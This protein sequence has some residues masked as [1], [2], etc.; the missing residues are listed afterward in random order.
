[1]FSIMQRVLAVLAATRDDAPP[2]PPSTRQRTRTSTS[3]L[4]G[5]ATC[6]RHSLHV[7]ITSA[8]HVHDVLAA[9]T[10]V[11]VRTIEHDEPL[12]PKVTI[13]QDIP[14]S[15]TDARV[16]RVYESADEGSVLDASSREAVV[17]TKEPRRDSNHHDAN[18]QILQK[19]TVTPECAAII[20][21]LETMELLD[22]LCS[23][24]GAIIWDPDVPGAPY[25]ALTPAD[26]TWDEFTDRCSNQPIPQWV[27]PYLR[28]PLLA[29]AFSPYGPTE[30]PHDS[31]TEMLPLPIP[32]F[33][34]S[35]FARSV[36][37]TLK[38]A[39]YQALFTQRHAYKA[40]AYVT[41]LVGT[42]VRAFY[43]AP[44]VLA[45]LDALGAFAWSDPAAPLL[46]MYRNC[47]MVTIFESE[48]ACAG[49]PHIV[50]SGTLPNAPWDVEPA[51]LPVQDESMLYVPA[52]SYI[53]ELLEEQEQEAEA[54]AVAEEDGWWRDDE[55]EGVEMEV[56]YC[57]P[58]PFSESEDDSEEARTPSPPSWPLHAFP[59]STARNATRLGNV[60]E[61]GEYDEDADAD[62]EIPSVTETLVRR[63]W[64]QDEDDDCTGS[65]ATAT[66]PPR[67]NFCTTLSP[68]SEQ[69]PEAAYRPLAAGYKPLWTAD[70]R[71][72]ASTSRDTAY[73]A[74]DALSGD[75][76]HSILSVYTDAL[77]EQP[78]ASETDADQSASED[79][80]YHRFRRA[81][82]LPRR[83]SCKLFPKASGDAGSESD[84]SSIASPPPPRPRAL[85]SLS[86]ASF[87]QTP[88]EPLPRGK[89]NIPAG[90][91]DWFDLPDDDLGELPDVEW[92]VASPISSGDDT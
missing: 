76:S 51:E 8:P 63:P 13:A 89:A 18:L 35:R 15:R 56:H 14:L 69:F 44:S 12:S 11:R 6:S 43:D 64:L 46:E 58:N 66:R 88:S 24:P 31:I 92:A 38:Q 22:Y 32:V 73:F 86:F 82:A 33:S 78:S 75:D 62:D 34:P 57:G 10:C 84:A 52:W 47:F 50:V 83:P 45:R 39:P 40:V 4:K 55:R 21:D 19:P 20:S 26:E 71:L 87:S 74:E 23:E 85:P 5:A 37:M 29:P 80:E 54:C 1:M 3:S 70:A 30:P 17:A 16:G 77:E 59:S 9:A 27:G 48:H 28:V 60:F 68:I 53:A 2:M 81:H 79:D 41:A 25:L 42:S 49:V 67:F 90:K 91:I 61:K 7:T 36:C 72:P 65:P